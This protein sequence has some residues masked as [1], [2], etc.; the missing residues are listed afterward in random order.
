MTATDAP[1]PEPEAF[2]HTMPP[3]R[4]FRVLGTGR[5]ESAGGGEM[6]PQLYLLINAYGVHDDR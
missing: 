3:D 5:G 6:E 4:L 2:H 1:H